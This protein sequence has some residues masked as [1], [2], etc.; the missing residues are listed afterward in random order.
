M[1]LIQPVSTKKLLKSTPSSEEAYKIHRGKIYI[2]IILI[3]YKTA[4][5]YIFEILLQVAECLTSKMSLHF[6]I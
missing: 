1:V 6:E 3:D 5:S 4:F 2:K